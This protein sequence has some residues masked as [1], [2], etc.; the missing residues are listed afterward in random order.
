VNDPTKARIG[1]KKK[2]PQY[3]NQVFTEFYA[4]HIKRQPRVYKD[5]TIG[6]FIHAH[7]WALFGQVECPG[8]KN[9]KL[10]KLIQIYRNYWRDND[11]WGISPDFT[12]PSELTLSLRCDLEVSHSPLVVP[13]IQEAIISAKAECYHPSSV[14]SILPLELMVLISGYV[15]HIT[16]YTVEDVQN[17]KNMLLGF[18]W[19]LPVWFWRSRLDESLFFE[20][21]KPTDT[22]PVDWN[23]RLNLMSLVAG[24]IKPVPS[25]LVNRER[26]LGVMFAL[27]KPE[28]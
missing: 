22:S 16:E 2:N 4:A 18:G 9:I 12:G 17:L 28:L 14:F 23:L 26:V 25:G 15:C 7:C 21:E 19:E 11:Y 20:L 10:A 24:Q 8:L 1:G 13:E 27:K 3:D 5:K 6:Y